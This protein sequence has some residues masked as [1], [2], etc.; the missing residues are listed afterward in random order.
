MISKFELNFD[1]SDEMQCDVLSTLSLTSTTKVPVYI[2]KIMPNIPSGKPTI[3]NLPTNGLGVFKNIERRPSITSPVLKEANYLNAGI[4]MDTNS[5]D[6]ES[7]TKNVTSYLSKAINPLV[8]SISTKSFDMT[9]QKGSTARVKF[10]N[11]KL[12]KLAFTVTKGSNIKK[13]LI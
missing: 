12:S 10:L 2:N 7:L 13:S 1:L 8:H 9:I 11:N 6:L 3:I 4:N 5:S